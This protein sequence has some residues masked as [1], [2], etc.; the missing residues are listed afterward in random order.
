MKIIKT[1]AILSRRFNENCLILLHVENNSAPAVIIFSMIK[2]ILLDLLKTSISP[3]Y[4]QYDKILNTK[5][6]IS[7]EYMCN[8]SLR[9]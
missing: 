4:K 1:I 6:I 3:L 5:F 8:K 2:K 7:N 9:I